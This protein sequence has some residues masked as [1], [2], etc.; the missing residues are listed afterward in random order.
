MSVVVVVNFKLFQL[1]SN[2]RTALLKIPL[3][4]MELL[5]FLCKF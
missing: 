5:V 3:F 1:L 2:H 4:F